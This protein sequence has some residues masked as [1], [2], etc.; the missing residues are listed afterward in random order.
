MPYGNAQVMDFI[1]NLQFNFCCRFRKLWKNAFAPVSAT[2]D[3]HFD[4]T[5]I[6]WQCFGM[7][8]YFFLVVHK[9]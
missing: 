2:L 7:L 6:F 1:N 8:N 5:E 4:I 3:F 9:H